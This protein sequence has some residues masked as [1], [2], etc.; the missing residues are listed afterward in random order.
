MRVGDE[1]DPN[2]T[3]VPVLWVGPFCPPNVPQREVG[4]ESAHPFGVP[5]V[6]KLLLGP[7]PVR[8]PA[9]AAAA[10]A[11]PASGVVGR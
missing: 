3:E 8:T 5:H 1:A 9:V 6:V 4:T 10:A 7:P 11:T 2:S